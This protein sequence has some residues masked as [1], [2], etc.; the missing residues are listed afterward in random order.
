VILVDSG[1]LV[2]AGS[3]NDPHHQMCT[4]LLGSAT[5]QLLVPAAVSAEV[6]YMLETRASSRSEAAFL[7]LF[8]VGK[9]VPVDLTTADY[10]RMAELVELYADWPLG[11]TDASVI[12]I[13]ER[14]GV[15]TGSDPGSP[16]LR[17]HSASSHRGLHFASRDIVRASCAANR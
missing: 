5:E 6:C 3:I 4:E 1:P 11:G 10:G 8:S 13:A 2:A 17:S 16:S 12:A 7:R 14:L 15:T 9:L